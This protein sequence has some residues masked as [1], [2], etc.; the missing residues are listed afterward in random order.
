[1]RKISKMTMKEKNELLTLEEMLI[2]QTRKRKHL[3]LG[4][5]QE[6]VCP[7]KEEQAS[8]PRRQQGRKNS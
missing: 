8:V 3:T 5:S 2:I 6:N 7:P 1:M 4:E